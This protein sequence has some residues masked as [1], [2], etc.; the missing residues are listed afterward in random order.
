MPSKTVPLSVRV[1][2]DDALF[3]SNLQIDGA[4]TPSEKLRALLHEAQ[5]RHAG[6]SESAEGGLLLREMA[7]GAR[8]R[9]RRLEA[10]VGR[11][12][13]LMLKLYERVP[14]IMAKL[15]AGPNGD[16]GDDSGEQLVAFEQELTDLLAVLLKDFI[17]VGLSSPAR[18]YDERAYRAELEP[19]IQLVELVRHHQRAMKGVSDE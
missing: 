19:V 10:K 9:L 16:E 17:T 2:A 11:R 18:V 3:L 15:I 5:R 1:S 6:F 4:V 7:T 12:S 13:D 8:R 14:D